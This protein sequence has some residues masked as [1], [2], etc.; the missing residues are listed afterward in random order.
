[1]DGASGATDNFHDEPF[2]I[3]LSSAGPPL[4]EDDPAGKK[5]R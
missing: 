5:S 2:H 1:M 3:E 4:P